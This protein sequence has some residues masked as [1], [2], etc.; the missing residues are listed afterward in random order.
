[1]EQKVKI[2]H[3]GTYDPSESHNT[4]H[5]A[6][7]KAVD[8]EVVECH[9]PAPGNRDDAA[10]YRGPFKV[11]TLLWRY[12]RNSI[13]IYFRLKQLQG[14]DAILVSY[15]GHFDVPFAKMAA[16]RMGIPLV[17]NVHISLYET[18]VLDRG[19]FGRSSLT[20]RIIKLYERFIFNL[21]DIVLVDTK[22]HGAFFSELYKV[23]PDK[24]ERVFIGAD[25]HFLPQ[26]REREGA[27][28]VLFYGTFIPLQGIEHIIRAAH[29]LRDE[30]NLIFEIIG[31][32]QTRDQIMELAKQLNIKNIEF[33]DWVERHKLVDRIAAADVCLGGQFGMTQK[34]NLV[35]GYKCFQMLAVGRPVIV[36][37]SAGNMELLTHGEDCYACKAGDP[38]AM[39]QA[40]LALKSDPDLCSKIAKGALKTFNAHCSF[41][42]IGQSLERIF[43]QSI[44]DRTTRQ[45]DLQTE[46]MGK[47]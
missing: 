40:I 47:E 3:Y 22:T 14:L 19:Y 39:S 4:T 31:R 9:S 33:F 23:P 24:F 21:S 27:F 44:K 46:M 34:A 12:V 36:A 41:Y 28:R 7:L 5:V 42:S 43:N 13:S 37:N 29:L 18:L 6:G 30:P 17:F 15:P 26:K 16:K 20:A 25:S 45:S 2:C 38:E 1:M 10:K 8:I 11:I 35:I 32:G